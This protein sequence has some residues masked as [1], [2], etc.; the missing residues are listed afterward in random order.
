M[1]KTK[2]INELIKVI[3]AHKETGSINISTY[4]ELITLVRE[5]Q[6]EVS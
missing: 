4:T 3:N 1:K 5:L 2:T 6:V